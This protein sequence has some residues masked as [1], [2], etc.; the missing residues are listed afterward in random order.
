VGGELRAITLELRGWR[1][2]P[3][4]KDVKASLTLTLVSHAIKRVG[5]LWSL[6][7]SLCHR[8]HRSLVLDLNRDIKNDKA[9]KST[10]TFY[11]DPLRS[12]VERALERELRELFSAQVPPRL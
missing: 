4:R 1:Y 3:E 12:F 10:D 6:E 8:S 7:V 5:A 9:L 2:K 11:A